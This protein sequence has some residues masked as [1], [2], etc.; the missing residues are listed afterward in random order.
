[1]FIKRIRKTIIIGLLASTNQQAVLDHQPMNDQEIELRIGDVIAMTSSRKTNL[2][3]GYSIGRNLR[4]GKIGVYPSYK[5]FETT[6]TDSRWSRFNVNWI[7][8]KCDYIVYLL[9]NS[10]IM[11]KAGKSK[12]LFFF[13]C[14]YIVWRSCIFL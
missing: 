3:N 14:F 4:T 10:K 11:I 12:Q 1:M 6:S 2:M 5:T 9:V 13:I 8:L 7:Y